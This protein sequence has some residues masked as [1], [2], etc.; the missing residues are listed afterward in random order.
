MLCALS[1]Q[2]LE[3]VE[4]SDSDDAGA[5]PQTYNQEQRDVKN[6]FLQVPCRSI[7]QSCRCFIDHM[8][9]TSSN[10]GFL[11]GLFLPLPTSCGPIYLHSFSHC[12]GIH[13][14]SHVLKPPMQCGA[15]SG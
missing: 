9:G 10:Y 7:A 11:T 3:G 5:R 12:T 14:C 2:A 1:L 4:E 15:G 6:A 13:C 8:E